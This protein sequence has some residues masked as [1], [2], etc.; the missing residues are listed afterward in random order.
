MIIL[1]AIAI[2][3]AI[4]FIGALVESGNPGNALFWAGFALVPLAVF[5]V[6][7][8]AVFID[9]A[10]VGNRL[11][12]YHE[13]NR[14]AYTEA[15]DEIREGIPDTT[16]GL[17]DAANLQQIES[18]GEA[19]TDGRDETVWF[20]KHLQTRRFWEKN[21]FLGVFIPDLDPDILPINPGR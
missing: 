5:L 9:N 7:G 13:T 1:I 12:A 2:L 15:I 14:Y 3:A 6:V 18:F 8:M 10:N 17:F 21:L 11:I 16:T 4:L 20:N 19:V